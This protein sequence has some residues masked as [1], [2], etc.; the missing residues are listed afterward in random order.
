MTAQEEIKFKLQWAQNNPSACFLPYE[1]VDVRHPAKYSKNMRLTC[2]C[3]LDVDPDH[4]IDD[5]RDPMKSL[6]ESLKSGALPDACRK[7][8][9]EEKNGAQS[10]R[11]R[12]ILT[13]DV[14][15]LNQFLIDPDQATAHAFELMVFFST[16]CSLACRSCNSE[17]STTYAKITKIKVIP[18]IEQDICEKSQYWDYITSTILANIHKRKFLYIH[19]MGGEPVLQSGTIKLLK[20]L[21]DQQIID[22]IHLRITTSMAAMPN[23]TLLGYFERCANVY[24]SLSID[25]VGDNY[26]YVRWPAAFEKVERNLLDLIEFNRNSITNTDFEFT[27]AP[28]FSLNNIFYID[29]Y[30][31]YWYQWFKDNFPIYFMNTNVVLQTV[32]LDIQALPIIYRKELINTLTKCLSHPVIIDYPKESLSMLMFL[33]STI[34]ELHS[35]PDDP[36]LWDIFL[37]HVAEFDVRTNTKFSVLNSKLYRLLSDQDRILFEGKSKTVNPETTMTIPNMYYQ[38]A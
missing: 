22:K 25:S 16:V 1:T 24:V 18:E 38:V 19:L 2:C 12:T 13:K 33:Q 36:H 7:C 14:D 23:A 20:W 9:D 34:Q 35:L 15:A 5:I 4:D 32:H 27:L 21:S 6:K 17:S 10:E 3:N 8:C 11:I 26:R 29:D 30:L 31:D 28:V 37:S